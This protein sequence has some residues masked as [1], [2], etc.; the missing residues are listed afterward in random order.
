VLDHQPAALVVADLAQQG[1][2]DLEPDEA[3]RDVEG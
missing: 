1:G 2:R 3:D